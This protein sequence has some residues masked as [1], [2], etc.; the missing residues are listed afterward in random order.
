MRRH[1]FWAHARKSVASRTLTLES[2]EHRMML[3]VCPPTGEPFADADVYEAN[4]G[5]ALTVAPASGLLANDCVGD[6]KSLSATLTAGPTNG[7]LTLNPDGS[8]VYTPNT[9]YTGADSFTYTASDGTM[10]SNVGTVAVSVLPPLNITI[11]QVATNRTLAVVDLAIDAPLFIDAS[12]GGDDNVLSF[13]AGLTGGKIVKTA[14]ADRTFGQNVT[15]HDP[16]ETYVRFTTNQ[17]VTVFVGYHPDVAELPEWLEQDRG[18]R[19]TGE[20]LRSEDF[21][22]VVL[23]KSFPTGE[24]ILGHNPPHHSTFIPGMYTVVVTPDGDTTANNQPYANHDIYD[25]A[26]AASLTSRPRRRACWRTTTMSSRT[27]WRRRSRSSRCS[28]RCRWR[29]TARLPT[30]RARTFTRWDSFQYQVNDG[31][32]D[33]NTTT[34]TILNGQPLEDPGH[35]HTGDEAA[36]RTSIWPSCARPAPR[37]HAHRGRQRQLVRSGDVAERH[38]ADRQRQRAD[39]GRNDGHGRWPVRRN[40]ADDARGR[41]IAIQPDGQFVAAGRYDGG[42]SGGTVRDGDGGQP[43]RGEC[44]RKTDRG[45][46]RANRSRLGP[47]W[48]EPW[49]YPARHDVNL[50]H[51]RDAVF[52]AH[53]GAARRRHPAYARKRA[54]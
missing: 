20:E 13:S 48:A 36:Q 46:S 35:P 34:V 6:G 10:T 52:E 47:L 25:L 54:E 42:R 32:A 38:P 53:H 4:A 3:T 1:S 31:T 43:D 22:Y 15:T 26:G 17:S 5:A 51:G 14:K 9:G 16:N 37:G 24:I 19:A 8:F 29:R 45:R 30:R 27:R 33:G 39:P 49:L 40:A 18:W 28:A 11:T 50:R 21:R 7:T 12:T 23:Q 2:I 41:R 44:Y